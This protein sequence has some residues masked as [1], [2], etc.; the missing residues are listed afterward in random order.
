M[1]YDNIRKSLMCASMLA[2]VLAYYIGTYLT[3]I[4]HTLSDLL[5]TKY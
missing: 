3:Y 2:K 5:E 1:L 4:L